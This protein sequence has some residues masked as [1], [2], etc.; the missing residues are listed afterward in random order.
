MAHLYR[1]LVVL[2]LGGVTIA[3]CSLFPNAALNPESGV[4]LRLPESIPGYISEEVEMS[5]QEKYWLP[6]DTLNIKQSY[7][8][9]NAANELEAFDQNFSASIILSGADKRSLH[10]PEVC[11]TGQGWSINTAETKVVK[12]ETEGGPLEVMDLCLSRTAE[13]GNGESVVIKAHYVYWWVGRDV[14]TP[15]SYKRI[16]LSAINNVFKNTN[17]RWAY[18][19]VMV[20]SI[21]NDKEKDEAARERAFDYIRKYAPTFQKSLGA[22]E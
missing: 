5:E 11:M 7:S 2:I 18:P 3:L 19:S 15:H 10:R 22:K 6:D 14:S 16:L 12:L 4:I 1:T 9:S 13:G 20:K 8:F 17:D 21:G